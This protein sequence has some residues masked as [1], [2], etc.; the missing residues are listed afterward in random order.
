MAEKI[1]HIYNKLTKQLKLK[2]FLSNLPLIKLY[3]I[4]GERRKKKWFTYATHVLL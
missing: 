1:I 3:F 2:A 4:L